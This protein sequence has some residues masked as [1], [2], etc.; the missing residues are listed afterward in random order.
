MMRSLVLLVAAVLFCGCGRSP[1]F[2]GAGTGGTG[3]TTG[4]GTSSQTTMATGTTATGTGST[5]VVDTGVLDTGCAFIGCE[6]D[7]PGIEDLPVPSCRDA[8]GCMVDCLAQ[9]DLACAGECAAGL[10]P[11]EGQALLALLGCAVG[12]CIGDGDCSIPDLGPDCFTCIGIKLVAP[13]P[14]G[15]EAEAMACQ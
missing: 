5:G 10:P 8:I 14:T 12:V 4:P 9:G 11:E 7:L 6:P 15:C 1:S 3:P 13:E 2:G